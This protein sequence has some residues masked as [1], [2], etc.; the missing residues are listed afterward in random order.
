MGKLFQRVL[1]S[2][3]KCTNFR[4]W[5]FFPWTVS[6]WPWVAE[7]MVKGSSQS[8]WKTADVWVFWAKVQLQ[9]AINCNVL[10]TEWFEPDPQDANHSV[11]VTAVLFLCVTPL[12]NVEGKKISQNIFSLFFS[13][14]KIKML[15]SLVLHK[16]PECHC[17]YTQLPLLCI[18]KEIDLFMMSHFK[19]SSLIFL[20]LVGYTPPLQLLLQKCQIIYRCSSSFQMRGHLDVKKKII[21]T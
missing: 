19:W 6:S 11:S 4:S 1:L 8:C 2:L 7:E 16:L 18:Q 10:H 21:W 9:N 5:M 17:H 13:H 15:S 3:E 14:L 12:Y 20:A